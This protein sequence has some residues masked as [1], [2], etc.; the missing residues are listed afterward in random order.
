MKKL[1]L[2]LAIVITPMLSYGQSI[3]D[4][5]EDLDEVTSIVVNQKMF[6]MIAQIDIDMDDQNV[7]VV[8]HSPGLNARAYIFEY[9]EEGEPVR[10]TSASA[11]SI[12]TAQVCLGVPLAFAIHFV[13]A[14]LV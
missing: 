11:S 3:F 9:R 2:I 12:S 5:F 7:V 4:K 14:L 13:S 10:P 6:S 8:A 1:I